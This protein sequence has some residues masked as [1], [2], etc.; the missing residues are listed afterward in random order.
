M[1]KPTLFVF[2][3]IP[4]S[5]KTTHAIKMA[6]EKGLDHHSTDVIRTQLNPNLEPK[7]AQRKTWNTFYYRIYRSLENGRSCIAD[8]TNLSIKE[9]AGYFKR[10]SEL[11]NIVAVHIDTPPEL[12]IER[13]ENRKNAEK[14]KKGEHYVPEEVVLRYIDKLVVPTKEEGFAEVITVKGY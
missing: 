4:G 7:E 9:R 6:K 8:A 5:G 11:A 3:G 13:N 14:L 12:C 1:D 2:V 10:Y